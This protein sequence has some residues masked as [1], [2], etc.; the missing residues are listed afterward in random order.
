MLRFTYA[1]SLVNA[2]VDYANQDV[3]Q[4]RDNEERHERTRL[5][6]HLPSYLITSCRNSAQRNST[7]KS[8]ITPTANRTRE[9]TV[10]LHS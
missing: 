7:V 8:K 1:P 2:E 3:D 6:L 10:Y 9:F 4:Q 5:N